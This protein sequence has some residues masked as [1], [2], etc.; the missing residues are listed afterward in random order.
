MNLNPWP[1]PVPAFKFLSF[2]G[3]TDPLIG[4][5]QRARMRGPA[6]FELAG[7]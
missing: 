2:T 4:E 7:L 5:G 1:D 3:V 6:E